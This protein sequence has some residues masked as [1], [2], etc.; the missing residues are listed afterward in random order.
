M[1]RDDK[2]EAICN[3]MENWDVD[4]LISFAKEMR[5][6]RLRSLDD[7]VLDKIYQEDV[8]GPPERSETHR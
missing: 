4:I 5:A 3:S 8:V 1:T 7:K 6:E 2:I